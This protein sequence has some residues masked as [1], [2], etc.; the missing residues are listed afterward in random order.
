MWAS[1]GSVGYRRYPLP[2]YHATVQAWDRES[3]RLPISV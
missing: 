3:V 2:S 1:A